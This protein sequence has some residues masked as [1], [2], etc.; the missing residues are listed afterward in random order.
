MEGRQAA[1]ERTDQSNA[2]QEKGRENALPV[3]FGHD[4]F[5]YLLLE[6][7]L[8]ELVPTV[9][10]LQPAHS[11]LKFLGDRLRLLML[12]QGFVVPNRGY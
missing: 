7:P 1:E 6:P 3:D 4:F 2:I 12:L 9:Q 10:V 8:S 11:L 5:F